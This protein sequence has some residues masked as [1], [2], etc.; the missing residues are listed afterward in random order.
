MFGQRRGM[1]PSL[2][3]SRS[4]RRG[5][6]RECCIEVVVGLVKHSARCLEKRT[7]LR[8][9]RDCLRVVA[10]IKARLQLTNPIPAREEGRTCLEILLEATL[11]EPVIAKRA[12][13][14]RQS[15]D[16]PNETELPRHNVNHQTEACFLREFECRLGFALDLCEWIC[17]GETIRDEIVVR[18]GC[19]RLVAGF[20]CGLQATAE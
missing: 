15:P 7:R 17:G 2:V 4:I 9:C 11:V 8:G 14:R 20:Q 18:I 6:S 16:G 5:R 10:C 19:M 12:E 1:F 3:R 13:L